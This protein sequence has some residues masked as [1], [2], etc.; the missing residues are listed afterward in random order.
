M[1]LSQLQIIGKNYS[2]D[3]DNL[4]LGTGNKLHSPKTDGYT[5]NSFRAYFYVDL[6]S[7]ANVRACNLYFGDDETTGII[8]IDNG[9]FLDEP[10]GKA[11]RRID[12]SWHDIQGRR[13]NGKPST[14]GLYIYNGK[15]VV[16][17]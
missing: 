7:G 15:K 12:N 9:Q 4:Y 17:K 11:E 8:T 13:L 14:K 6:S 16:I 5:I 3:H 10:S 2:A 1:E